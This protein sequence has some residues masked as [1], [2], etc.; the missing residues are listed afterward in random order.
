MVISGCIT[1]DDV[2]GGQSLLKMVLRAIMFRKDCI[3]FMANNF[4]K[5][6]NHNA[7]HQRKIHGNS[8]PLFLSSSLSS[9]RAYI[10]VQECC[11]NLKVTY[12]WVVVALWQTVN[13]LCR[14]AVQFTIAYRSEK[15]TAII[16]MIC[17]FK[18]PVRRIR[19]FACSIG[20][21]ELVRRRELYRLFAIKN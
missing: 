14:C 20:P 2:F 7:K 5:Y 6:I 4:R 12:S 10:R 3:E 9:N 8:T 13:I 21:L 16:S 17:D 18:V 19:I 1:H 11:T 15:G